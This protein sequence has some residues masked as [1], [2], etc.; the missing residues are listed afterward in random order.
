MSVPPWVVHELDHAIP[1]RLKHGSSEPASLYLKAA[2]VYVGRGDTQQARKYLSEAFRLGA[3]PKEL[4]NDHI[5]GNDKELVGWLRSFQ[6]A[7]RRKPSAGSI[8]TL[9]LADPLASPLPWPVFN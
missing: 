9:F 6:T 2:S 5:I 4:Q 3:I 1:E 8:G 7:T